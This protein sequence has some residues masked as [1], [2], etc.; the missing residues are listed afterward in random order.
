MDVVGT[1]VMRMTGTPAGGVGRAI[2]AEIAGVEVDVTKLGGG[3]R[4]LGRPGRV[5]VMCAG[6]VGRVG[7][8]KP[9]RGKGNDPGTPTG[10]GGGNTVVVADTRDG[11]EAVG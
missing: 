1:G 4:M 8:P 10:R 5:C 7:R 11:I 2:V 3:K 9:G 6:G